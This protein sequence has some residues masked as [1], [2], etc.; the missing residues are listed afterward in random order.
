MDTNTST[1]QRAKQNKSSK[2]T[3]CMALEYLRK[4]KVLWVNLNNGQVQ[5]YQW[6][7]M[8]QTQDATYVRVSHPQPNIYYAG[9]R[10]REIFRAVLSLANYNIITRHPLDLEI[11]QSICFPTNLHASPRY[12]C[13]LHGHADNSYRIYK[14]RSISLRWISTKQQPISHPRWNNSSKWI[15]VEDTPPSYPFNPSSSGLK[16]ERRLRWMDL[17]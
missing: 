2:I 13:T 1:Q 15:F 4:H 5:R 3:T 12:V 6:L 16:Y 14:T 17:Y 8:K 9:L 7:P 11:N 10:Q